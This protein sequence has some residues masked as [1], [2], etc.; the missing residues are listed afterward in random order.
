MS[1]G[2]GVCAC[3]CVFAAQGAAPVCLLWLVAGA[4]RHG[5]VEQE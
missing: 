4:E 1:A 3:V 2:G 5:M